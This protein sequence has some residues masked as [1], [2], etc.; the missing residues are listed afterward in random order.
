MQAGHVI[1]VVLIIFLLLNI[2]FWSKEEKTKEE[3]LSDVLERYGIEIETTN[4][5]LVLPPSALHV[6]KSSLQQQ[7][8]T[9]EKDSE[10]VV[11]SLDDYKRQQLPMFEKAK[12]VIWYQSDVNTVSY[13]FKPFRFPNAAVVLFA[14]KSDPDTTNLFNSDKVVYGM[15]TPNIL[16]YRRYGRTEEI[17]D[18][19]RSIKSVTWAKKPSS[20]L[21]VDFDQ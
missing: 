17:A 16:R 1:I 15:T 3:F 2:L 14:G 21:D 6:T 9:A 5:K 18:L 20:R 7:L 4:S 10:I 13:Q 19:G 11:I 12:V 8:T